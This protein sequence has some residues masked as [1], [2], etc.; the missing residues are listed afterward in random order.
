[1]RIPL[2][3]LGE[4]VD[5]AP[6]VRGTDVAAALVKVG[7][8]EEGLHGGDLTG[9]LVV[10]KVLTQDPEPQKNGK[11]INWCTVDVG[12]ANGTGEP[13]GIVCG[14]HNFAPGD[15]V[16]VVLPGAVLPGGFAIAARKTYGHVS[17]GM[18]CAADELGLPDDGSGG[19]IRLAERLPGVDLTPGQDAIAL[20]GLDRETVEINVT[21][22][23]GYCFSLR[24]VAREY[25]HATGAVFA[26]PVTALAQ[27]AAAANDRGF[28][29]RLA[30][31]APIRDRVGCSRYVARIVRGVDPS[32][33]SPA[34]LA[35]RLTEAGMRP[36]S[37]PVDVTNYVMLALGQ[38]LHA[39]DLTALDGG[40][41]VRRAAPGETLKTLDGVERTLF[42]EDLVIADDRRAIAIAGT[43]G[44][45]ATEVTDT[46]TD[47]LIE[48]ARFDQTS[49]ARS[50][51]RHKL[52]SEAAK[53]FERGVDP[54]I[55]AAAA[56]FAVE[57]LVEHGG[58][59]V[60]DGVTDVRLPMPQA[61]IDFDPAD[62]GRL[63]GVP[64]TATDVI[65]VLR[66]IGCTV[67]ASG[68]TLHVTPP[69]WRPDLTTGPDLTEEVARIRGYEQIPSILPTPP[70]GRGLTHGQQVRRLVA[71]AL[72]ARGFD[73][74]WS[75][76]FV[77]DDVHEAFGW[78]PAQAR[79]RT[80]ALAN[81][82]SD[83][84]PLFRISLLTTMVDVLRRNVSRGFSDLALFE[85]GL[86]AAI[87]GPLTQA[88]YSPVGVHPSDEVLAAIR[89]SVPPQPRHL[90]FLLT[91]NRTPAGWTGPGRP[92]DWTDA[93]E[94]VQAIGDALAVPLTVTQE[95][96]ASFHPG[97]SGRVE[98]GDGTFLGHVGELHPKTLQRLG[99][100]P[101]V[102]GGQLLLDELIRLS[103]AT[104]QAT[105]LSV[106][107]MA[108]SDVA[109]LVDAAVPAA[110]VEA[111]LRDGAG[112]LLESIELFDL[113]EG[114]QIELGKKS[115]AYRLVFR[116][117]DRTLKTEE[118]NAFRDAAVARAGERVGAVQ[119]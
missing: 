51:R 3:W 89:G 18:I 104:P 95:S 48:A 10:G 85:V 98:A 70:G 107:P 17:A 76:P 113:Y 52:P 55:A 37:L 35:T 8:E 96:T 92:A 45:E 60:D 31:E 93:L 44:G 36:I 40:I 56:Q 15:F 101:R 117:P 83:E 65:D 102:V 75:A 61:V 67:D 29:V 82:L 33:P 2:D 118:V 5:L 22:D 1:M 43:M 42:D 74:V 114:E 14:A 111:A 72:A 46:T 103:E 28:P 4:Y 71:N 24:G 100:P 73:E 53:R 69:S 41:T 78:D 12:D 38:P 91:G 59:R 94:A 13:Q 27:R 119:R 64:Y 105:A 9:P 11:V 50:A 23:R 20:L 26:D 25:S 84:Q 68:D 106:M 77:G 58:G 109:L 116:A 30:D 90:A 16:V 66:E 47:I 7:L 57:L 6:G 86:V 21:P 87:D 108:D 49:V 32:A 34:W 112:E 80:V 99:L 54:E 115:L 110:V 63:V 19:I 97:R 88:P 39:F 79:A 62:A 81:P